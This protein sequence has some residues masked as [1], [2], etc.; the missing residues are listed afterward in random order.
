MNSGWLT[1]RMCAFLAATP[2]F[3]ASAADIFDTTTAYHH[4]Q[5]MET[6]GIRIL[7]FDRAEQTRMS[8]KQPLVGH[9]EYVEFFHMPWIWN[10]RITNVLMIGLGGGSAQRL[11]QTWHPSVT[12]DTVELDPVVV[13]VA[14]DY[15]QLRETER[16]RVHVA[17][18]R[19]FLKRSSVCHDV[20]LLDAYS[21]NRYGSCIPSHL[22]TREFFE[23][24]RDHLSTNGVMAYNVI[25]SIQG[26]RSDLVGAMY[27]TMKTVFP[28][29][30]LF[31]AQESLNV[32]MIATR[33]RH[34]ITL[35]LAQQR[36]GEMVNRRLSL[37]PGIDVRLGSFRAVTPP[38][39]ST[40]PVFTDDHAPIEGLLVDPPPRKPA[41]SGRLP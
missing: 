5:V 15:F 34:P 17:D 4:I 1:L 10:D 13:Q 7:T 31:P 11:W 37:P 22:A 9:F 20:V 35:G 29:V 16:L 3:V 14:R 40:S 32:V 33:S 38:S 6:N 26:V 30:Y 25:G 8:V 21:R 18:G 28:Q 19:Q 12:I 27:R 36:L 2:G 23:L 24:V 41:T 39:A